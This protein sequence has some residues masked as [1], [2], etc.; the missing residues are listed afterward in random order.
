MLVRWQHITARDPTSLP[1]TSLP[2]PAHSGGWHP[3]YDDA[4]FSCFRRRG[5]RAQLF[6]EEEDISRRRGYK[7]QSI[8][9]ED[10][11]GSLL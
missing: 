5:Y 1:A 3:A 7:S 10:I 6:L 11:D 9:E 2:A 4:R 8:L